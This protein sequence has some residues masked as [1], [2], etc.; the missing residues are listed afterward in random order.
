MAKKETFL[1]NTDKLQTCF[2][3]LADFLATEGKKEIKELD[4]SLKIV[5]LAKVR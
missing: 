4:I 1:R 2:K 3:I 5:S